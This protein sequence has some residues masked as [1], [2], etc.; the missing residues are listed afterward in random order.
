[1]P[2]TGLPGAASA[3]DGI[4]AAVASLFNDCLREIFNATFLAAKDVNRGYQ[5]S[6]CRPATAS[7]DLTGLRPSAALPSGFER[8]GN[9]CWPEIARTDIPSYRQPFW[10]CRCPETTVLFTS[11]VDVSAQCSF[12]KHRLRGPRPKDQ[13]FVGIRSMRSMTSIRSDRVFSATF[14]P[15]C[16]WS[17]LIN[18]LGSGRF[19]GTSAGTLSSMS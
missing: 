10:R 18:S 2:E 11:D 8:A 3:P 12:Q 7:S 14:R 16:F 15:S 13:F 4:A 17:A 5:H 9:P 6:A 19:W 1:M